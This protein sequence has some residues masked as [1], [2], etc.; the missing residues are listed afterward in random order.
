MRGA[1]GVEHVLFLDLNLWLHGCGHSE[2]A[3]SCTLRLCAFSVSMIHFNQRLTFTLNHTKNLLK[4]FFIQVIRA[5][6]VST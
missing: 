4:I 6:S 3:L 5:V 2:D 1:S